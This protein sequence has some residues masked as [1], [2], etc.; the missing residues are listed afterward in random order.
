MAH[1]EEFN[2]LKAP[3][4][5]PRLEAYVDANEDWLRQV[6]PSTIDRYR[7]LPRA[8][9]SVAKV[10]HS[11]LV[12]VFAVSVEPHEPV[13]GIAIVVPG[14]VMGDILGDEPELHRGTYL[15]YRLNGEASDDLHLQTGKELVDI[16]AGIALKGSTIHRYVPA[17]F[18]CEL[19]TVATSTVLTKTLPEP[20]HQV[21][22]GLDPFTEPVSGRTDPSLITS[23]VYVDDGVGISSSASIGMIRVGI[24]QVSGPVGGI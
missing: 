7:N 18:G 8:I 15:D 14:Q 4:M 17:V 19:Q 3:F 23:L 21:N 9:K 16:A 5:G 24:H 22:R 13:Q 11:K 2:V 10:A 1:L 6:S 12:R 20:N